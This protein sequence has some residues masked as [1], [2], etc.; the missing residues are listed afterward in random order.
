MPLSLAVGRTCLELSCS[1]VAEVNEAIGV[2]V[3]IGLLV[4]LRKASDVRSKVFVFSM[5]AFG[6]DDAIFGPGRFA[7]LRIV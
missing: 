2:Q 3:R 4:L 5:I 7:L 6:C 1:G